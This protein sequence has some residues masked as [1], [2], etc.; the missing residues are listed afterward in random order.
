LA[1]IQDIL[2]VLFA[3]VAAAKVKVIV[4]VVGVELIIQHVPPP[5]WSSISIVDNTTDVAVTPG[6][7]TDA[8]LEAAA[9]QLNIPVAVVGLN[10]KE[11]GFTFV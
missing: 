3:E 7:V 8:V 9:G 2:R 6:T 5:C 4:L 10:K 11:K 1:T